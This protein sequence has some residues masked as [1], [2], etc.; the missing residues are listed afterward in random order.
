MEILMFWLAVIFAVAG[1]TSPRNLLVLVV[2]TLAALSVAS[3]VFLA[4]SL[5]TPLTG[6]IKLSS[7]PLRDALLHITQPPLPAGA[8]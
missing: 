4:L 7:A 5:D 8:P 6:F 1:L 2:A 3:S